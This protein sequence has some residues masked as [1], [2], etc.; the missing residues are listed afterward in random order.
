MPSTDSISQRSAEIQ[1]AIA[2]IQPAIRGLQDDTLVSLS[3]D[4]KSF[5]QKNLNAHNRRLDLLY[6]EATALDNV[7]RADNA[8]ALD[9]YPNPVILDVPTK[10]MEELT[11]QQADYA[12]AFGEFRVDNTEAV[13][14]TVS[15]GPLVD[16]P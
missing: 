3:D 16:K 6:K 14:G 10:V 9:G 8:L 12:A 2:A 4:T 7:D 11:G 13:K 5:V 1:A 15:L